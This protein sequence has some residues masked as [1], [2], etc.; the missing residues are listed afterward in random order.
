MK[1][2]FK[3]DY[4]VVNRFESY[5]GGWGY[6]VYLVEV[7]CFSVDIDILF[8]GFGLFGGRGEYIVKIKLF[9]LGFDGG[10]YEIDGDFFVEI[11]VLVYDCVVREK[12]VM[13]FDEFVFL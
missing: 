12:Y 7:I 3:E 1:V 4:S 11:D 6:F 2:Y 10:D 9:E 13:M 8:G 5:G